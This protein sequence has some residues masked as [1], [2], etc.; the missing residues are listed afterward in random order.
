MLK[1]LK[2][3]PPPVYIGFGSIVVDDPDGMT[4]LIFKAIQLARVRALVSH[5]WGGLGAREDQKPDHIFML[6]NVPHDWLFQHVSAV[7]HHGGAGTTAAG[8]LAGKPTVVVP[9]FGDQPFWGSMIAHA[10]AGPEPIPYKHLTAEIL[11]EQIRI[12]LRPETV[13]RARALSAEMSAETGADSG[14]KSFHESLGSRIQCSVIPG[15]AAVWRFKKTKILLST[16]AVSIL[17]KEGLI[18]MNELKLCVFEF[19]CS[20]ISTA[21]VYPLLASW[22]YNIVRAQLSFADIGLRSMK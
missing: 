1:F 2:E 18:D 21:P 4:Q 14:A 17:R 5:G 12:A 8:I 19:P 20:T 13:E 10:G 22:R 15:R 7:I 16:K 11:A 9:F 3:G 6:G